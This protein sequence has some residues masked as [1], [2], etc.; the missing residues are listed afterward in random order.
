MKQ[1]T[2][3]KGESLPKV[4]CAVVEFEHERLKHYD[5]RLELKKAFL[6]DASKIF[7]NDID[8]N[9]KKW[10]EIDKGNY[11]YFYSI[12]PTCKNSRGQELPEEIQVEIV[13]ERLRQGVNKTYENYQYTKFDWAESLKGYGYWSDIYHHS[14][15]PT[16]SDDTFTQ[17]EIVEV[18]YNHKTWYPCVFI[19]KYNEWNI[20][21]E[22]GEDGEE[23]DVDMYLFIRK[24]QPLELTLPELL[25][26]AEEV[27]RT[28][29]KLKS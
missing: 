18:S 2:N 26:I 11:D 6:W 9:F 19:A 21:V 27:K 4:I 15:Y 25:T 24:I 8:F 10:Q 7:G 1:Y 14:D 20:A 3:S 22:K 16:K 29:V 12:F 5:D 17:G 28:K 13:E 23:D